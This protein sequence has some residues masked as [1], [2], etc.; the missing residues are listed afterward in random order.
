MKKDFWGKMRFDL[1]YGWRFYLSAY[2]SAI[3]VGMLIK[4]LVLRIAGDWVSSYALIV[5]D[6]LWYY[7]AWALAYGR[8][9]LPV[10]DKEGKTYYDT[11]LYS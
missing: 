3:A 9:W 7:A 4:F 8:D 10:R 1:R 5:G 6:G 2:L 11:R